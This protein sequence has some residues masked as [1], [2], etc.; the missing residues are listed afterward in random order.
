MKRR[1][2]PALSGAYG[3][4]RELD[5]LLSSKRQALGPA[6]RTIPEYYP[7]SLRIRQIPVMAAPGVRYDG[8]GLPPSCQM[9][10]GES[11]NDSGYR[12]IYTGKSSQTTISTDHIVSIKCGSCRNSFDP[13]DLDLCLHCQQLVCSYCSVRRAH[14]ECLDC[15]T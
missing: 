10:S 8:N 12:D 4:N 3:G 13:D 5:V 7:D 14:T 11:N 9:I 2:E 6:Q 1:A 15:I